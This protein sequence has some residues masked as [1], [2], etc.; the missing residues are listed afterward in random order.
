MMEGKRKGIKAIH[1]KEEWR[2][3]NIVWKGEG[4][5]LIGPRHEI[6][7]KLFRCSFGYCVRRVLHCNS[8]LKGWR[9]GKGEIWKERRRNYV[10][11]VCGWAC[12]VLFYSCTSSFGYVR[13]NVEFILP[14]VKRCWS[15]NTATDICRKILPTWSKGSR[16]RSVC[17]SAAC[18][19]YCNEFEI[20]EA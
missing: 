14:Y 17:N 13:R 11:L 2:I 1:G 15:L 6:P 20:P 4:G 12:S 5:G 16:S 8:P 18:G 7:R 9:R 3:Q 19:H 10:L